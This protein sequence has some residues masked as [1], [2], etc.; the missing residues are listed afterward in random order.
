[1]AWHVASAWVVWGKGERPWWLR[2]NMP[3]LVQGLPSLQVLGGI[4]G[5]AGSCA[6]GQSEGCGLGEGMW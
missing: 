2:G 5:G 4:G 6:W 1:M 3:V